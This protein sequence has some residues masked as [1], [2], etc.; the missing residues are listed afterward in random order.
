IAMNSGGAKLSETKGS[1][2]G[3]KSLKGEEYEEF[4]R[5]VK[6][7]ELPSFDGGDP[8]GWISRAEVYFRVQETSPEV[9]VSLAQLC[10]EGPTIHFFNSLLEDEVELTWERLKDA[11]LDRYGG[12]GAGDV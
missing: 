3:L 1:R 7:I 11:L 9:R 12:I 6:K 10:M 4:R 8:A 2:S 5:S